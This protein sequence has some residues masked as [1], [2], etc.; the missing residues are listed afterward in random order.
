MTP[1]QQQRQWG[2]QVQQIPPQTAPVYGLFDI[3]YSRVP[4]SFGYTVDETMMPQRPSV[5][6]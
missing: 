2:Q 1:Q 5:R 3:T 6:V 4:S